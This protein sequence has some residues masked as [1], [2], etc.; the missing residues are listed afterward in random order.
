MTEYKDYDDW[1]DNGPGSESFKRCCLGVSKVSPFILKCEYDK[2]VA[3]R[4][5][6][7]ARIIKLTDLVERAIPFLR[8]YITDRS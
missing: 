6:A 2:V 5:E 8:Q 1:Y 4:D 3:E 7:R